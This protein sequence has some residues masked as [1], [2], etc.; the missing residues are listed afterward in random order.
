MKCLPVQPPAGDPR[1]YAVVKI[2]WSGDR[3][4]SSLRLLDIDAQ[5]SIMYA[6]KKEGDIK[7]LRVKLA[8][9]GDTMVEGAKITIKLQIGKGKCTKYAVETLSLPECLSGVVVMYE[10]RILSLPAY[11][12]I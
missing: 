8:E 11:S 2:E 4:Q 9:H 6:G 10:W 12:Q 1:P 3:E 7:R 5:C